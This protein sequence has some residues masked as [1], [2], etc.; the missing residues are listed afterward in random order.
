MRQVK[1]R[2][3]AARSASATAQLPGRLA[4]GLDHRA[5]AR[6]AAQVARQGLPDLWLAGLA[7]LAH[8][9]LER[10]EE[11]RRAEAALQRVLPVLRQPLDRP[12][13]PAARLRRQHEA[14]THRL[15]VQL[16]RAGAADAVLAADLG[17][18]QVEVVAD[19]VGKQGPRL[20]L[21]L[22]PLAVHLQ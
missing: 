20:H 5:V 19:K 21:A 2:Y 6:A 7:L 15:A 13:A 3:I 10:H 1:R 14:G 18:G 11:P 8:E 17:A 9:R 4:D 22:V 12:H 16:D